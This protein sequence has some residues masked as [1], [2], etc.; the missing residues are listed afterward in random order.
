MGYLETI[1]GL[2][3]KGQTDQTGNAE[4][5]YSYEINERNE[6]SPRS[7]HSTVQPVRNTKKGGAS[8][9]P[10]EVSGEPHATQPCFA[11]HSRR[12][13]V[14]VQ[15]VVNC[16][17]CHPP[18]S[19]ALVKQWIVIPEQAGLSPQHKNGTAASEPAQCPYFLPEGVRL[20]SYTRKAPP[21]EVT[22]SSVVMDVPKFIKHTL[23]ELDARL[24]HPLQIKA[25]DSVF[26]LVSK[27]GD[28][29][30]EVAL[31]WPPA[32]PSEVKTTQEIAASTSAPP[33]GSVEIT[34]EDIPF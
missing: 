33:D 25:G 22:V 15:G 18:A 16:A 12:F 17:N 26:Q 14:S 6:K 8:D 24:H 20:V 1:A 27:L 11:C 9:A 13:W 3:S 19:P 10:Q 32:T 5:H 30:L 2:K 7:D 29:G 31:E 34:D 28:C 23:A 21:V 4:V